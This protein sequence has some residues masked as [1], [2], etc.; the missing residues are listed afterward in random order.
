MGQK[1]LVVEKKVTNSYAESASASVA[2]DL[3]S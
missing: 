1:K 2:Q 3:V